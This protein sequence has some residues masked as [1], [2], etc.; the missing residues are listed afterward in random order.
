MAIRYYY[1]PRIVSCEPNNAK[2]E[3]ATDKQHQYFTYQP[4]G[5]FTCTTR[6]DPPSSNASRIHHI[7]WSGIPTTPDAS[8][9][10]LNLNK[11]FRFKKFNDSQ[12]ASDERSFFLFHTSS[13]S[14]R[15]TT[16]MRTNIIGIH[17]QNTI[18]SWLDWCNHTLCANRITDLICALKK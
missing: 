3:Y 4:I 14:K 15:T 9:R 2:A 12:T 13:N 6:G 17:H 10:Q 16:K 1:I 18:D 11:K 8:P 7:S 5:R